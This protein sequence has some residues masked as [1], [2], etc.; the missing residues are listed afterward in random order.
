MNVEYWALKKVVPTLNIEHWGLKTAVPLPCTQLADVSN[1]PYKSSSQSRLCLDMLTCQNS[2]WTMNVEYWALKKVVPTLNIEHWRSKSRFGIWKR[3]I[4]QAV[5]LP[6]LSVAPHVLLDYRMR[7]VSCHHK[8][9]IRRWQNKATWLG[10]ICDTFPLCKRH[11]FDLAAV[12]WWLCSVLAH[13]EG[14]AE[15]RDARG[16]GPFCQLVKRN[17]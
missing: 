6:G 14:N 9:T 13:E 3:R 15:E 11:R 4:R 12:R 8:S 16:K 2:S 5:Q 10:G 1:I 7:V 17:I